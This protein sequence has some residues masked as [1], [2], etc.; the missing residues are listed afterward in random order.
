MRTVCTNGPGCIR[1]IRVPYASMKLEGVS[2]A[3]QKIIW[4][5]LQELQGMLQRFWFSVGTPNWQ[6]PPITTRDV[7]ADH[8][9]LRHHTP[10]SDSFEI[11]DSQFTES[12]GDGRDD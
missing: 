10:I 9:P 3:G 7:F 1:K 11:P 8:L 12:D 6:M 2:P 5:P 4:I